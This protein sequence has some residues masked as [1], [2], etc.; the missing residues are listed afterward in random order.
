MNAGYFLE[1]GIKNLIARFGVTGTIYEI[2][3]K[4]GFTLANRVVSQIIAGNVAYAVA[5]L[6]G[7][8][9]ALAGPLGV[10]IGLLFGTL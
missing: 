9:G 10:A 4:I 3:G 8:I 7:Q 1:R 6:G 2:A 5:L